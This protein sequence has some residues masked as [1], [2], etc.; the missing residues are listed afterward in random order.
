MQHDRQ[1]ALERT[2]LPTIFAGLDPQIQLDVDRG[3]IG[4]IPSVAGAQ[5]DPLCGGRFDEA[6]DAPS[7]LAEDGVDVPGH[8][9]QQ[10]AGNV[11]SET[12]FEDLTCPNAAVLPIGEIVDGRGMTRG[13]ALLLVL[14]LVLILLLVN[15]RMS[16][17]AR[18]DG[19]LGLVEI[20][21]RRS[22]GV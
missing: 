1:D 8:R 15:G 16:T 7:P 19:T 6:L 17:N 11:R 14:L 18:G 9:G 20:P 21:S 3:G 4:I 13:D 10:G 22:Q 5:P 2:E 12:V